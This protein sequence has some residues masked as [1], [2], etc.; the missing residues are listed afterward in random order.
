M[1]IH[2][3]LLAGED[4]IKPGAG[5]FQTQQIACELRPLAGPF[6]I[7]LVQAIGEFISRQTDNYKTWTLSGNNFTVW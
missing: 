3:Q 7:L 1:N 6:A 4:D 5:L 2:S